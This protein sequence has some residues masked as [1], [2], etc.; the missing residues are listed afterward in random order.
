MTQC[1]NLCSVSQFA[2][3][4]Y[5]VLQDTL[6][7][8]RDLRTEAENFARAVSVLQQPF[9]SLSYSAN[10][11]FHNAALSLVTMSPDSLPF[12][13]EEYPFCPWS[14]SSDGGRAKDAEEAESDPDADLLALSSSTGSPQ[15]GHHADPGSGVTEAGAPEPGLRIQQFPTQVRKW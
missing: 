6:N 1:G 5:E 7:L 11:D 3:E 12:G 4:E 15:P 10:D 14:F 9:M 13:N 2:V 8:E